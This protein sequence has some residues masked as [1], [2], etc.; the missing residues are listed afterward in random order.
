V[1]I[2]GFGFGIIA[3]GGSAD[4]LTV[5]DCEV[6]DCYS[7]GIEIDSCRNANL[8]NNET[9]TCGLDGLKIQ[10]ESAR[11]PDGL[12][13]DG[14]WS[15]NNGQRDIA[16]G[17]SEDT[18]GNGIDLYDG[19]FRFALRR[20]YAFDNYG[21]GLVIKGVAPQPEMG[22]SFISESFFVNNKSTNLDVK[23]GIWIGESG[24]TSGS[25]IHITG[26]ECSGNTGDGVSIQGGSGI[27]VGQSNLS[28]NGQDGI[29]IQDA[30]NVGIERCNIQANGVWGIQVGKANDD[31][32]VERR[33]QIRGNLITGNYDPDLAAGT[34]AVSADTEILTTRGVMIYSDTAIIDVRTNT[35]AN[36]LE[37]DVMNYGADCVVAGNDFYDS[38]VGV[39][40]QP[41][42]LVL[43]VSENR[44]HG[45]RFDIGYS[46]GNGTQPVAGDTVSGSVSGA[47]GVVLKLSVSSG[48]WAGG[49]AIG[50]VYIRSTSGIFTTSDTLTYSGATSSADSIATPYAV[51]VTEGTAY[52]RDNV[53]EQ[54]TTR[55]DSY[56]IYVL[57]TATNFSHSGNSQ[58]NYALLISVQTGANIASEDL[59]TKDWGCK[60]DGTNDSVPLQAMF[61]AAANSDRARIVFSPG[62]YGIGADLLLPQIS[63]SKYK[64]LQIIGYGAYLQTLADNLTIFKRTG[65]TGDSTSMVPTI[66]GL[67]FR[68]QA[69]NTATAGTGIEIEEHHCAAIKHCDFNNL[70][71][72][73][74]ANWCMESVLEEIN[75]YGALIGIYLGEGTGLTRSNVTTI[76]SSHI[77]LTSATAIGIQTVNASSLTIDNTTVQGSLGLTALD[78]TSTLTNRMV[79]VRNFWC[80]TSS[81]DTVVAFDALGCILKL[82]KLMRAVR[83]VGPSTNDTVLIDDTGSQQSVIKLEDTLLLNWNGTSDPYFKNQSQSAGLRNLWR[84]DNLVLNAGETRLLSDTDFWT[85]GPTNACMVEGT[86]SING[87]SRNSIAV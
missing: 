64:K 32:F 12:N 28:Q 14:L 65:A 49:D 73:I 17:G 1:R 60:I 78:I 84:F 81:I 51:R 46:S 55:T 62:E 39:I 54:A 36:L 59:V 8:L 13:V 80:E 26:V 63:S 79:D 38:A 35:F 74:K 42:A 75:V 47:T 11:T 20:V 29:E 15:Y 9:H 34:D 48:T 31:T 23:H 86:Y 72:G 24:A 87:V 21:S 52:V 3:R 40:N 67:C 58:T 19:G 53:F 43:R 61:D 6:K 25:G 4:H 45:P 77:S 71:T 33:I 18:N 5:R 66:E 70:A 27:S 56:A 37:A 82:G 44:F 83:G 16:A 2:D 69:A 30:F 85:N 57:N 68:G 76:R 50:A 22:R 10:N 7:W 41:D